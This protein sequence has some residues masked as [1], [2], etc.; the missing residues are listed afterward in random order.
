MQAANS[1]PVQPIFHFDAVI[2][3]CGF[4]FWMRSSAE[5]PNA[6]GAVVLC[7]AGGIRGPAAIRKGQEWGSSAVDRALF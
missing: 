6:A 7:F 4:T 2:P 1:H 5:G 3:A